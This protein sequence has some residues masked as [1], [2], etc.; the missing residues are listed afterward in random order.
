MGGCALWFV[1]EVSNGCYGLSRCRTVAK[2]MVFRCSRGVSLS[3]FSEFQA[4]KQ[5]CSENVNA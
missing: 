5:E 3:N 4:G 1:V 2:T